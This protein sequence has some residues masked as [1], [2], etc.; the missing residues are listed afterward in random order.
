MNMTA[1]VIRVEPRSLLVRN[2][3]NGEEVLVFYRN[4]GNYSV[5]DRIR[6]NFNGQMTLSIPPQITAISIVRLS[7]ESQPTPSE[8]R[9]VVL[10]K[11]RDFLIVRNMQNRQQ[12]RVQYPFAHH[13]CVRQQVTVR[14]ETITL[15]T[16]PT[17]TATDI[18]P[19]C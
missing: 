8:I 6:I 1:T 10:Q 17:V 9:A 7:P 11:G 5:G 15:T 2:E 16:P 19:I 4:A 12:L 3:E 18:I 14:Y 13:F